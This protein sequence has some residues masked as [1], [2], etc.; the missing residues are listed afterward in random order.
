MASSM[1]L[2]KAFPDIPTK[3]PLAALLCIHF[4]N[5]SHN[6][7]LAA[8]HAAGHAA[9]QTAGQVVQIPVLKIM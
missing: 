2:C 5:A 6:A 7:L 1:V 4:T 3:E 8:D 9:G